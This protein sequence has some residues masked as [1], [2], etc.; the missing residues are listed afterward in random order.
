MLEISD[1]PGL[2]ATLNA[3]AALLLI[4]GYLSIRSGH[5]ERHRAFMLA[6][7]GTSVAFLVS[8][9][10]YHLEV[11][12]RPFEGRG[13][14]RTVY[15]AVLIPHVILAAAMVPFIIVTAL[16]ALARPV[17]V[18]PRHRSMD[19]TDLALRLGHRRHRVS[20]AVSDVGP[21]TKN[22]GFSPSAD[23]MERR[24]THRC[25]LEIHVRHW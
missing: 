25:P 9:S 20:D 10:I 8:Y 1:L 5:K 21:K 24:A 13:W 18:A 12:S 11:G 23:M 6:A 2:N 4:G 16:R 7:L 19:A 17:R 22:P 14:T 15:F 3:V